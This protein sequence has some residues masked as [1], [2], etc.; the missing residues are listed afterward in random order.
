M[1]LWFFDTHSFR[2]HAN[3]SHNLDRH[4]QTHHVCVC[5]C[6]CKNVRLIDDAN[7]HAPL[8]DHY[9][10][11]LSGSMIP[12]SSDHPWFAFPSGLFLVQESQ[13]HPPKVLY[14]KGSH[15]ECSRALQWL[16]LGSHQVPNGTTLH[17]VSVYI[18]CKRFI[19]HQRTI[20]LIFMKK[21][22]HPFILSSYF[23]HNDWRHFTLSH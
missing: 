13:W 8:Y 2:A 9:I 14:H 4:T 3:F 7:T 1:H 15:P 22:A 17:L 10:I 18:L 21:I 19:T 20:P 11:K 16:Y 23:T 5:V 12:Q 6:V